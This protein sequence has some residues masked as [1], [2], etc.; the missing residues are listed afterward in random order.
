MR[1]PGILLL[2]ALFGACDLGGR[3][4]DRALTYDG[5]ILTTSGGEVELSDGR[6]LP[7]SVSSERYRAWD[8]AQQGLDRGTADRLGDILEP[9]SPSEESI[10]RAV[11]FLESDMSARTAIEN[12]GISVRD[13]VMTTVALEQ[14]MRN[15]GGYTRAPRTQPEPW[16]DPYAYGYP[17]IDTF[18]PPP[19]VDPYPP[20]MPVTPYPSPLPVAPTPN[21]TPNPTPVYPYPVDTPRRADTVYPTPSPQSPVPPPVVIPSP[22]PTQ[23]P[24]P[25]PTPAPRDTSP[26]RD[27]SM[28]QGAPTWPAPRD[29]SAGPA[30][31]APPDST[32]AR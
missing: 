20:P 26:R 27:T 30:T 31:P 19:V 5:A 1:Y 8:A 14:E 29:T 13:F 12:A 32:R 23:Q 9:L 18:T 4:D 7:F 2:L 28:S 17:P 3:K 25:V 24:T 21:P 15:V 11:S 22:A 6:K 10:D 16:P